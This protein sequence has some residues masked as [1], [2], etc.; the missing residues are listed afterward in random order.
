MEKILNILV[1]S[2]LS[3]LF[4]IILESIKSLDNAYGIWLELYR[5]VPY[6]FQCSLIV[7]GGFL[8]T[9]IFTKLGAYYVEFDNDTLEKKQ[10]KGVSVLR[11]SVL[12]SV[13]FFV[14]N[15]SNLNSLIFLCDTVLIFSFL[16]LGK[17][18][19]CHDYFI[20]YAKKICDIYNHPTL[21]K[22]KSCHSSGFLLEKPISK[23]SEDKYQREQVVMRLK[24]C[25]MGTPESSVIFRRIALV[26]PFG[27]GKSSV[28]NM[29][30]DQINLEMAVS[31]QKWLFVHFDAWGRVDHTGGVQG[32]LLGSIINAISKVVETSSVQSIPSNYM[33]AI[34]NV[35]ATKFIFDL[36]DNNYSPTEQLTK[37]NRLLK[38]NNLKVC[39][40]IED[41]DRNED[42]RRVINSIAPLLNN[43]RDEHQ[44]SFIF[45]LGYSSESS[46]II[47]RVTD[48]RED[49]LPID[50]K[51]QLTSFVKA[52]HAYAENVEL[53]YERE[54]GDGSN[55]LLWN[56]KFIASTG[57]VTVN[58]HKI[59]N[60]LDDVIET[61]R[62]FSAIKREVESKWLWLRGEVN[63][64][65]L[66]IVTT[67][68][69]T[70]PIAYDFIVVNIKRLQD[71]GDETGKLLDAQWSKLAGIKNSESSKKLIQYIFPL[72]SSGS[73]KASY[74]RCQSFSY[75]YSFKN[76]WEVYLKSGSS[77]FLDYSDQKLFLDMK[78]FDLDKRM[79][80]AGFIDEM[81][82]NEEFIKYVRNIWSYSK[83]NFCNNFWSRIFDAVQMKSTYIQL[84]TMD[85]YGEIVDG[86]AN[87]QCQ[88]LIYMCSFFNYEEI[89]FLM[90]HVSWA[91]NQSIY[92]F[93]YLAITLSSRYDFEKRFFKEIF[94]EEINNESK[95][96]NLLDG[97]KDCVSKL[98]SIIKL[99]PLE[100]EPVDSMVARFT[101][102]QDDKVF[103][104]KLLCW[105]FSLR[106]NKT[107]ENFYFE[108]IFKSVV[109]QSMK[110]YDI[111]Q[112]CVALDVGVIKLLS[113]NNESDL[114]GIYNSA[115]KPDW[116]NSVVSKLSSYA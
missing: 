57:L 18:L 12:L 4:F 7:F 76:Y 23:L 68:K 39:V 19:A 37:L 103:Y 94:F 21:R 93:L 45:T 26:G 1:Y 14:L 47:S 58:T 96:L 69:I 83:R 36:I 2:I 100:V 44:I 50:I 20:I 60:S 49:L 5:D 74:M 3:I 91:L 70:D 52:Q 77:Q 98:F 32:V 85:S 78:S 24:A 43:F 48:Y 25:L 113:K 81:V 110:N 9:K 115:T 16:Y 101:P 112:D 17:L 63:F 6:F 56:G 33:T 89:D 8:S 80:T 22:R 42:A 62:D 75:K 61:A 64:D 40:F 116:I 31:K 38:N 41:M 107:K 114:N 108:L 66:L 65:D 102:S 55:W 35:N 111:Y 34:R 53:F 105:V 109:F 67:L 29:L 88:A 79:K 84:S 87:K 71:G 46:D 54:S 73:N 59:I 92:Y 106:D 90:G 51:T 30:E 13:L 72:W 82:G 28:L 10:Q 11:S 99:S 86:E 97:K 27:S 15:S 104:E 95:F